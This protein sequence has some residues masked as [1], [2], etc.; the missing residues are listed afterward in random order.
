MSLDYYAFELKP[1]TRLVLKT[2]SKYS[3]D[4][5]R[6][7]ANEYYEAEI[8]TVAEGL[9]KCATVHITS[10]DLWNKLNL[11]EKHNLVFVPIL[12]TAVIRGFAHKFY[13]PRPNEPYS[14]FG[15]VARDYSTAREFKK[16]FE[17]R[18]DIKMG[19]L[20]GYPKCCT[21]FF[22]ETWYK[23]YDPIYHIAVNTEGHR[24]IGKYEVLVEDFYPE[25]NILLRYAGIR[26]VPHFVCSFKC[27]Q[28][29]ELGE[30]FTS[31]ITHRNQLY[32]ILSTPMSWDCFKGVAIVYTRDFELVV[33]SVPYKEKHV[34]HLKSDESY[35]IIR[36]PKV[37]ELIKSYVEKELKRL[38][39][40]Q[41]IVM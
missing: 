28:S 5:L 26:A 18:D 38:S 16:A 29:K 12:V 3:H 30:Q 35:P 41:E 40:E 20:L 27:K 24:K 8:K 33:N 2:N 36:R 15:V 22:A 10:L 13:Q 21:K 25:C 7:L 1:F 4:D 9:R 17:M 14:V 19:E 31:F 37:I 23:C 34:V 32:N 39:S 6:L 11:I